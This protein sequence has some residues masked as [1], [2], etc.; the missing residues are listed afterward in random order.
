MAPATHIEKRGH[1]CPPSNATH[2]ADR[3]ESLFVYSFICKFTNLRSKT[4]GLDT[5][6]DF[7]NAL[8]SR[9]PNHILTQL[10]SH[11]IL[12]LKPQTRNLSTDQI[13]ITVATVLSEYF[14]SSERTI[15]WNDDLKRN[16]DPFE[17]LEGGFFAADWNF[18]LKILRQLVELQLTHSPTIKNLIDR[19][20]GV[21]HNKHKRKDAPNG[22]P[23]PSDP[24]SQE[25]LQL[26]PLG[27]DRNR[28]RF[29]VADVSPRTYVST[30][31]WKIT[32]T[33]QTIS[34]TREEYLA[35][36]EQL[37]NDAPGPLKKGEKRSRLDQAHLSLIEAMENR[38][39]AIDAEIARVQRAKRKIEQRKTLLAQAE[40]R[41]TRTRRRTHKPDYVYNNGFDS[42]AS[43]EISTFGVSQLIE[44]QDQEDA[45]DYNYEEDES[46]YFDDDDFPN[47]GTN[48]TRSKRGRVAS[49]I[50]HRRSTRTAVLN[51]NGKRDSSAES[52]QWRE[53]RSTR[54]AAQNIELESDG[55]HPRKRFRTAESTDGGSPA[56]LDGG[57]NGVQ[58]GIKVKATGAAALKPTEVAMEQVAGKRK[59]KYW[60]Y[61]VEPVPGA[62][63][64]SGQEFTAQPS[65][66]DR[67]ETSSIK[68]TEDSRQQ[69]IETEGNEEQRTGYH[70]S[71]GAY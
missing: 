66:H 39:E 11:F 68:S 12:N 25:D 31:P 20:W 23:E 14:K 58:N 9:E 54:Q 10:L 17:Q 47:F 4:E 24:H 5:P 62:A 1:I 21:V 42:Q 43:P 70:V 18:K 48:G 2:P 33:F 69:S 44:T 30:N 27:Q 3:W 52:W 26:V 51:A 32:A 15:F 19:A 46:N 40:L 64:K 71:P 34:S 49:S 38:I 59:S 53:R 45:D 41:E 29:W 67:I 61:A 16:V 13:S 36:L 7:E 50:A 22:P 60:V 35:T 57:T 6:M 37:R 65:N 55:S 63:V 56:P 28:K 8:M